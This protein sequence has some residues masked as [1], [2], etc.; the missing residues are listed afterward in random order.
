MLLLPHEPD[1]NSNWLVGWLFHLRDYCCYTSSAIVWF[2]YVCVHG[3]CILNMACGMWFMC[4]MRRQHSHTQRTQ[5]HTHT[6]EHTH[7][8]IQRYTHNHMHTNKTTRETTILML[9][10]LDRWLIGW[11][12]CRCP[13]AASE[14]NFVNLELHVVFLVVGTENTRLMCILA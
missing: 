4:G 14:R 11:F 1:P 10:Q 2:V 5:T 12:G 8:H 7:T 13:L 3:D 6:H 9:Q